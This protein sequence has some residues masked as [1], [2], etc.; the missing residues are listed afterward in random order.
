MVEPGLICFEDIKII[1]LEDR[2]RLEKAYR[3]GYMDA[4]NEVIHNLFSEAE[5]SGRSP[6]GVLDRWHGLTE[7][8]YHRGLFLED[9]IDKDDCLTKVQ[10]QPP[11]IRR[12]K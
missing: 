1:P 7:G 9:D 4:A 5:R 8:W 11:H 12:E 6:F 2:V 10:V 3:K